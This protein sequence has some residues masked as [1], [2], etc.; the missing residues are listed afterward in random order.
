LIKQFDKIGHNGKFTLGENIGDLV[1]LRTAYRAAFPK[2]NDNNQELKKRF[3]LQYAKTWCSVER[4]GVTERR[5]KTDPHAL[6][7]AR[8]NEPIKQQEGFKEAYNCKPGDPMVLPENEIVN[9]W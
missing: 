6:E 5:L 1:G 8:T 4:P 7:Y 9:I 3:F 2:G